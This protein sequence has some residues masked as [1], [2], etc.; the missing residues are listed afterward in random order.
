MSEPSAPKARPVLSI[1]AEGFSA[2]L[3]QW[4][5]AAFSAALR[6]PFIAAMGDGVL[7][8]EQHRFYLIQDRLYLEDYTRVLALAAARTPDMEDRAR[9]ARLLQLTVEEEVGLQRRTA[10]ELGL[11][12]DD[13]RGAE[14]A[15]V[16]RAYTDLLVRTG[17]EGTLPDLLALLLPCAQVYVE[18]ATKLA[19]RGLPEN[20]LCRAWVEAYTA[21]AMQEWAAWL[22][23]RLDRAAS[24][25]GPAERLR[26]TRLYGLACRYELLFFETIWTLQ[27]W[28]AACAAAVAASHGASVSDA[29]S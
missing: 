24:A 3:R 28:P 27:S 25:A 6:H 26:W 17:F 21:P 4:H 5:A 23:A 16:T 18:A 12:D 22:A 14:P 7:R 10:A 13:L 2:T 11:T 19:A 29:A 8:P 9:L 1:G 15:L 20:P